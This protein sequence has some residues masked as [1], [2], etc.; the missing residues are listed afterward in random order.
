MAP[1][2]SCILRRPV[3]TAPRAQSS[4]DAVLPTC[5]PPAG[6]PETGPTALQPH[7]CEPCWGLLA[8][9]ALGPTAPRRCSGGLQAPE[10]S[11]AAGAPPGERRQA[12][13]GSTE[14]KPSA[15][16]MRPAVFES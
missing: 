13:G 8:A 9:T 16:S 6:I 14:R 12:A 2:L 10:A 3:W 15:L 7:S 11:A 5:Q 4:Q 1:S